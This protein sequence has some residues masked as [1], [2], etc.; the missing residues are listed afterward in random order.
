[1]G[2]E[3]QS[4]A[5]I[6]NIKSKY[7]LQLIFNYLQKKKSLQI[8]QHNKQV[9]NKL[10]YGINDYK[11]YSGE[12]SSIEIELIPVENKYGNFINISDK[13]DE[14]YYHIFFNDNDEE[15]DKIYFNKDDEV[16]KIKIIIDYQVKSFKLLFHNCFCIQSINF[17]KFYRNNINDMSS[18]FYRCESLNKINFTSFNTDNVTNM[19]YMFSRCSSLKELN[20][21]NFNTNNVSDMKFMFTE[22]SS[23]KK[24]DLSNF[25]TNNVTNMSSMFSGCSSLEELNL[26]NFNT[27]NV[28]DMSF[29]FRYCKSLK[30]LDLSNFNTEKVMNMNSMFYKCS[31]IDFDISSF[32]IGKKTNIYFMFGKRSDEFKNE[33]N[34]HNIFVEVNAF[35][36]Y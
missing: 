9:Q 1:M 30:E 8:I 14:I 15:I 27:A 16:T 5:N 19:S 22:C 23:L 21:Y 28:I 2:S 34:R 12:F 18:M 35:Y 13:K 25:N 7:I 11:K 36:D 3:L 20:L 17:I 6:G 10:N 32:I 24:L 33:I 26:S 29:M 4:V 31:L